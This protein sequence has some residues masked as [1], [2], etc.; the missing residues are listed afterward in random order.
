MDFV[1]NGDLGSLINN[2]G[3]LPEE[4]VR[5]MAL[6]LVSALKY[7]HSKG[8]THRDI[9]PDNILVQSTNPFHI[10]L[11]DFGLSKMINT[12]DTFLRTF[13]GTLLYCAPEVYAE[14]RE[15]DLSGARVLRNADKRAL[16]PQRYGQAVDIWSLA[17]V[18]FYSFCNAPPYPVQNGVTY[19]EL[20]NQIMTQPLDIRPLQNASVSEH[21]IRF[22]RS[23][24]H[25]RPEYRATIEQLESSP[26]LTGAE[27]VAE[28]QD[29]SLNGNVNDEGHMHS[30]HADLD[31]VA[32]QLS[33]VD[34]FDDGGSMGDWSVTSQSTARPQRA[35]PGNDAMIESSEDYSFLGRADDINHEAGGRLFGEVSAVGSSGVMPAYEVD[36]P[37]DAELASVK[38]KIDPHENDN[39]VGAPI[40]VRDFADLG[41]RTD[42]QYTETVAGIQDVSL[43]EHQPSNGSSYGS[44]IIEMPP[45]S[46]TG[47]ESMVGNLNVHSPM[48]SPSTSAE[49][50][51]SAAPH[52]NT[53]T[54]LQRLSRGNASYRGLRGPMRNTFHAEQRSSRLT[55]V[56]TTTSLRRRRQD[57]D[58][59]FDDPNNV[60]GQLWV[61]ADLPPCKKLRTTRIPQHLLPVEVFWSSDPATHHDLYPSMT[62]RQK[63]RFDDLAASK[64]EQFKVGNPLFEETMAKYRATIKA[65]DGTV[66]V[67][68][69]DQEVNQTALDYQGREDAEKQL[70]HEQP[71]DKQL[72]NFDKAARTQTPLND[73]VSNQVMTFDSINTFGEVFKP[74]KRILAKLSAI[75]GSC[76]P[77][78]CLN[79]T[80]QITTWGRGPANSHSYPDNMEIRVSLYNLK[81]FLWKP[82]F[83][84][85]SGDPTCSPMAEPWNKND[86]QDQDL[87]FYISSKA[88]KGL[89]VNGVHVPSHDRQN[90]YSVAKSWGLLRHGDEVKVFD[91]STTHEFLTL[92]FECFW[93]IS[94]EPR[95]ETE[96][97]SLMSEGS[98]LAELDETCLRQQDQE[99]RT[100]TP[101]IDN[102]RSA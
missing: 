15:Y 24:L 71:Q 84:K 16:P 92:R 31:Q 102:N 80:D 25:I 47:A 85:Y 57:D 69:T 79:V 6:Q 94:K 3:R 58:E 74:P 82:G 55:A 14:Y 83:R 77:S 76:L 1:P 73:T 36:F 27:D 7:L 30:N 22:V 26:W 46:L 100:G 12:E 41:E 13:C 2:H 39:F 42:A 101:T 20:L 97:F 99:A 60:D 65:S 49:R 5:T 93:G 86:G 51:P 45:S 23:M 19:H 11:T 50:L 28:S 81:L 95:K 4:G 44:A 63:L 33:I 61:P 75:T 21:G 59:G 37:D 72:H 91:S 67:A 70:S 18:L 64:G 43:Q 32:S 38:S 68:P 52:S 90:P 98:D 9:K 53:R 40:L 56:N 17:G 48:D 66:Q 96:I 54:P 35:S 62:L 34:R 88:T 10:K 78:I 8:I 29:E 87:G 89:W